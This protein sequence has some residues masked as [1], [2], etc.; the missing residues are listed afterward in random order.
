MAVHPAHQAIVVCPDFLEVAGYPRT[1][2]R[3]T[4]D[5]RTHQAHGQE[6]RRTPGRAPDLIEAKGREVAVAVAGL[7]ALR[8]RAE[9]GPSPA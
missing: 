1:K 8:S 4:I 3:I 7:R 9:T 6:D 2:V 5:R